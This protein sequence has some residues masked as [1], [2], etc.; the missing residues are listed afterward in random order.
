MNSSCYLCVCVSPLLTYEWL[1][2]SLLILVYIL[3]YDRVTIDW[4]WIDDRILLDILIQRMTTFANH[5]HTQTSAHSHFFTAVAWYRIQWRKFLFFWV[6]E[7]SPVSATSYSQ[8]LLTTTELQQLCSQSQSYFMTG[9]L[10]PISS[11]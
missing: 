11:T 1:N 9:T 2:Q 4:F 7:L 6:P 5:Y 8:Q 10:P 3:S